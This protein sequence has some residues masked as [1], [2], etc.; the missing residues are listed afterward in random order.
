[1]TFGSVSLPGI[2]GREKASLTVGVNGTVSR[3]PSP[4][5][6]WRA[7]ELIAPFLLSLCAAGLCYFA[8]GP[9]LGL[10]FGTFFVAA[11]IVPPLQQTGADA[12]AILIGVCV[13]AAVV[14]AAASTQPDVYFSDCTKCMLVFAAW[15]TAL[16][17]F[18]Q[19]ARAARIGAVP[20]A[21]MTLLAALAWLTWPVWL[22]AAL[23]T[24]HGQ[25]IVDLL[26]PAH[27]LFCINGVLRHFGAWDHYPAL[28][29]PT[30]TVLNQD[31]S[32]RQPGSIFPAV[33]LHLMFGLGLLARRGRFAVSTID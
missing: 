12:R 25:A 28:A 3:V 19:L 4:R 27:P 11:M 20:A 22:T 13:G 7:S 21:A 8:A 6:Q 24:S 15:V 26:V 17:G 10:F 18:G 32:Y 2:P 29:Y 1:M 33:L 30:L 14:W 5:A 9:T 16:L 31:V 23:E